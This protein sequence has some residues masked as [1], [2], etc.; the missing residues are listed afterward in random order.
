[1]GKGLASVSGQLQAN[2]EEAKSGPSAVLVSRKALSSCLAVTLKG[3]ST[4]ER[5]SWQTMRTGTG[6]LRRVPHSQEKRPEIT[7]AVN[8]HEKGSKCV[9]NETPR[10]MPLPT[11]LV[12]PRMSPV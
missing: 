3:P 4:V 11:V 5:I 2:C 9:R 6:F 1:M 10:A 12:V 7:V 8:L